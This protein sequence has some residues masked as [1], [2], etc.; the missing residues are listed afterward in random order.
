M[1]KISEEPLSE[2]ESVVGI[3]RK[4]AEYRS[5]P[6]TKGY[7]FIDTTDLVVYSKSQPRYTKISQGIDS[8]GFNP[9]QSK[10]NITSA[11]SSLFEAHKSNK[12]FSNM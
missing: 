9:S 4:I 3:D 5:D 8:M 7:D 11:K 6:I 10:V 2:K 12:E 1:F